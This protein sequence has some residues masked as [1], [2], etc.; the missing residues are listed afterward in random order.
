MEEST[1]EVERGISCSV[2]SSGG[3]MCE[4]QYHIEVNSGLRARKLFNS[5]RNEATHSK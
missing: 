4:T 3:E 5:E 2:A 1:K